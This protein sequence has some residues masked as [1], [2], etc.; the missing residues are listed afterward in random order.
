M[1]QIDLMF[2]TMVAEL[3]QRA[4]A[5][6]WAEDFP[7]SGRFVPVAVDGR[8]YWYFDQPDCEGGQKRRYVGPADD[9]VISERVET[10]KG[11]KSDYKARRKFVSTLTREAGLIAPDRFTG[12]VVQALAKAG[13]FPAA[14]CSHRVAFQCYSAYLGI[15]LPSAAILTGDADLAQDFAISAEVADSLP[16][17]LDLLK[18]LDPTFR[19]VPHISG[20]PRSHAFRNQTGYR[21]EFM[22]TNRGAEEYSD[23]PA[24]MPALGGASAEPLRF[25]DFLI[26]DPVRSILLYGAGIS[27]VIP[28]PFRYAVHKLIVAGRRQNDAGGQAKR[29]KD[30]RQAGMLFDAL[31][32]SGHGPSLADAVEEAWNR[33]PAW[34]LAI[35]EA[36]ETMHKEYWGGVNRMVGTLTR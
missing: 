19:A 4:F 11:E 18:G 24:N 34:K 28:D 7:P 31:P 33:G 16:P 2:R 25:M 29:D 14:R 17:I 8:R 32:V 3:Q 13:L 27:V 30:L 26:R 22:T 21:V 15:R 6:D 10:F 23:K 1:K 20:S 5:D 12:D 35:S 9:P 36:A